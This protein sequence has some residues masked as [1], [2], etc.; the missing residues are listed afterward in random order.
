MNGIITFLRSPRQRTGILLVRISNPPI[1]RDVIDLLTCYVL[2]T[3]RER[4]DGEDASRMADHEQELLAVA[5]PEECSRWVMIC[6]L[7]CLSAMVV[8]VSI[9][10][11]N[12]TNNLDLAF[13][14]ACLLLLLGACPCALCVIMLGEQCRG[15]PGGQRAVVDALFLL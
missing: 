10:M 2:P 12:N 3:K 6:L 8:S 1:Y 9:F 7:G 15:N 14:A 5:E 11:L 4:P 13:L